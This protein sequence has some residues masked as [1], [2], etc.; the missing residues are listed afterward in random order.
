MASLS[1]APLAVLNVA[2]HMFDKMSD[3]DRI[4]GP[5]SSGGTIPWFLADCLLGLAVLRR[6][7]PLM[8]VPSAGNVGTG[9][10]LV[11][12]YASAASKPSDTPSFKI[13]LRFPVDI[14][15][16]FDFVFT[17]T[18]MTKAAEDYKFVIV[19]EFL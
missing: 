1:V 2:R 9:D 3:S 11:R 14:N 19:M 12:S 13:P 17:E 10:G 6:Y 7:N 16:E 4:G 8:A 15:N 5:P 18:E